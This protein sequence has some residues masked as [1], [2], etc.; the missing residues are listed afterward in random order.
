MQTTKQNWFGKILFHMFIVT[1][2]F[3][4]CDH[5]TYYDVRL[6]FLSLFV[7]FCIIIFRYIVVTIASIKKALCRIILEFIQRR[8]YKGTNLIC[9]IF[10]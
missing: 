5:S 1:S 2:F 6:H 8:L 4:L 7:S 10:F 9:R 3:D